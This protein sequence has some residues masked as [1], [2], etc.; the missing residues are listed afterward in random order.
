[1]GLLTKQHA[2][3]KAQSFARAGSNHSSYLAWRAKYIENERFYDGSMQ[4]LDADLQELTRRGEIPITLNVV[5]GIIDSQ[6]GVETQSRYRVVCSIDD[7]EEEKRRLG[8]ALTKHML[9]FQEDQDV[10][11]QSSL[12]FKD[13]C[14]GGIG[15]SNIYFEKGLIHYQREDP[16]NIIPDSEDLTPQF[17]NSR[18]VIKIHWLYPDQIKEKFKHKVE[19]LN[20]E[21]SEL[22]VNFFSSEMAYRDSCNPPSFLNMGLGKTPIWEVQFKQPVKAY[23]GMA[24]NGRFFSTFSIEQ[25]EKVS[26]SKDIEEFEDSQIL[27]VVFLED[28]VLHYAPLPSS[29][30]QQ[31][32]F[33]LIPLVWKRRASDGVCYGMMESLKPVQMD[34]NAR[35]T[36][37]I[38]SINS[39]KLFIKGNLPQKLTV[40]D[41]KAEMSTKNSI[42]V[43]D[44]SSDYSFINGIPLG[45]ENLKTVQFYIDVMK[46]ISGIYDQVMGAETNTTSGV[47]E[48][49]KQDS[50]IRNSAIIFSNFEHM[51]KREAKQYLY[52]LQNSFLE[53]I[54]V[55]N[56]SKKDNEPIIM[57]LVVEGLNG[58]PEVFNDISF[59]PFNLYIDEVP[60]F[61]SNRQY[62]TERLNSLL[63]NPHADLIMMTPAFLENIVDNAEEVAEGFR[64]SM[65]L[66]SQLANGMSP[67]Q[68]SAEQQQPMQQGA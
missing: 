57:N 11:T 60:N 36:K 40:E 42:I 66:K 23:Q 2:L 38:N 28:K 1:M 64:Q 16:L 27:R 32:D 49:I 31:K 21:D 35:I 12:K 37:A 39:T 33:S 58:K 15:W 19:G 34:L 4:W 65:A 45:E 8:M 55:K 29:Y 67:Q 7:T 62:Q 54:M 18:Y 44:Q 56:I 59:L 17:T 20:F 51:K 22:G 9:D 61:K 50:S 53:N 47:A 25:A 10:P 63:N 43:L 41:L 3:L 13:A 24:K 52:T 30:P 48:K 68:Q 6:C 26:L 46:R 5:S 14:V